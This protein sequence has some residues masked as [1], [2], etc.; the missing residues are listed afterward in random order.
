[1][2]RKTVY[3]ELRDALASSWILKARPE[4]LPP[5]GDQ[6]NG[7]LFCGGRG[8]G[9]TRAGSEFVLGQVA[10]GSA[11]RIAL[12]APTAHDARHV[13][14]E[15]ESGL[16]TIAPP[17]NR[18]NYEPS[19]RRLS[20]KNGA[21]AFTFSSEEAD[22][23]RGP[24]HDLAWA[25]EVAPWNDP[26]ACWDQLMFGLRLGRH[27]RWL[28]TT[29]PRPIA[30]LKKLMTRD[31]V[32]ISRATTFDNE[33]N[34]APSFLASIRDKYQNTRLGRQELFAELL[35]DVEGSLFPRELLERARFSGALPEMKRVVVAVDPS[36]TSGQDDG[37]SCGIV[38]AGLGADNLAYVLQDLTL[39]TS[40]AVWG[41]VAVDAYHR[42]KADRLCAEKNYGG[43][44]VRHVIQ[45][46]DP[47]VAYKEL[48]ATRGKVQRAEPIASLFEQNRV[49][50]VGNLGQLEDQLVGFTGNGYA[51]TASPDR[52][53]A[54]IWALTELVLQPVTPQAAFGRYGLPDP[55]ATRNSKFDGPITSGM[56]C[57]G[58]AVSR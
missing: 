14:I 27:P 7:W 3:G 26:Q 35:E 56:L 21:E 8:A 49:R 32:V 31:D 25:D 19:R 40:P 5:Q 10:Q 29:T 30:L 43:A 18:P 6:W 45:T 12:V 38:V 41:R 55:V 46:V 13:M 4:Q 22:R 37:D 51:G 36:G 57:G 17:W 20:W 44:M 11:R 53:D 42:H 15:G 54:A 24:Q 52:A 50:L 58:W 2:S 1:M 47:R 28:A 39:K 34:L 48:T 23:L 16:L 33:Q 9:K